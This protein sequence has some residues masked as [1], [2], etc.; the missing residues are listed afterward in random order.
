MKFGA[1]SIII[2]IDLGSELHV[3]RL[4]VD[5]LLAGASARSFRSISAVNRGFSGGGSLT[6]QFK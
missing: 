1:E 6:L 5:G 2:G 3:Q 4:G